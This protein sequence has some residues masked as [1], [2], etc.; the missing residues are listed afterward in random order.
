[1]KMNT[2]EIN[3]EMPTETIRAEIQKDFD[4]QISVK[5][6]VTT[7]PGAALYRVKD[8]EFG[9][10]RHYVEGENGEL[11]QLDELLSDDEAIAAFNAL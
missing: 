1:M 5:T 3:D 8:E 7:G 11:F 2:A 10:V 9:E 6:L 4:G